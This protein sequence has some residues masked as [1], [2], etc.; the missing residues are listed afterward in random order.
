M[1]HRGHQGAATT[2]TP[3]R[4][5]S[6]PVFIKARSSCRQLG[7][8]GSSWAPQGRRR[9][10]RR[11]VPGG[12]AQTRTRPQG[13]SPPYPWPFLRLQSHREGRPGRGPQSSSPPHPTPSPSQAT[14]RH[15]HPGP[16]PT[17]RLP[18]ILPPAPSSLAAGSQAPRPRLH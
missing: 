6:S 5:R 11:G 2:R 15:H 14:S 8:G 7:Q 10:A 13:A 3:G 12:A 17:H 16:R 18:R 9:Y 4:K 1:P